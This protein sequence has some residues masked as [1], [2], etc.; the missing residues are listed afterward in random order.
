MG[1]VILFFIL[2]AL[3]GCRSR[4]KRKHSWKCT[5]APICTARG[6]LVFLP[7]F[8]QKSKIVARIKFSSLFPFCGCLLLLSF[9]LSSKRQF[10]ALREI[11]KKSQISLKFEPT[12][13]CRT[14]HKEI[15]LDHRNQV[16][17]LM[18]KK[19]ES[20]CRSIASSF[21]SFRVRFP[22]D[23]FWWRNKSCGGLKFQIEDFLIGFLSL[24]F[25]HSGA[26]I[27]HS[28]LNS[29]KRIWLIELSF[30]FLQRKRSWIFP[31]NVGRFSQNE[32]FDAKFKI[33]DQSELLNV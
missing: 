19:S 13:S 21:L 18:L 32:E 9:L 24:F 4:W 6:P 7:K 11:W 22:T 25:T 29:G 1:G 5:A 2:N 12:K 28:L 3:A 27:Q 30:Y 20:N 23:L 10:S 14:D 31:S 15:K 17:H 16:F 26:P 8:F 33:E